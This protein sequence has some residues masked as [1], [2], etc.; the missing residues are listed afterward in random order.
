MEKREPLCTVGGNV[1]QY[2]HYR[3]QYEY[4]IKKLPYDPAIPL[5]GIY[6]E[7]TM[8]QED[9]VYLKVHCSTIY[10]SQNKEATQTSIDRSKDKEVAAHIH[11]GLPW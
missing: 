8:I 6:S 4:F 2:T 10:N 1:N 9:H 11:N 7:K 3:E 5:L